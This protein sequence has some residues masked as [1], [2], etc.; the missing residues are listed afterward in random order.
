MHFDGKN[1]INHFPAVLQKAPKELNFVD[2]FY[3]GSGLGKCWM[4]RPPPPR[5]WSPTSCAHLSPR[6]GGGLEKCDAKTPQINTD[7]HKTKTE[8][9]YK[10]FQEL[11]PRCIPSAGGTYKFHPSEE[12]FHSATLHVMQHGAWWIFWPNHLH[13]SI[14]QK[15]KSNTNQQRT[16]VLQKMQISRK[17]RDFKNLTTF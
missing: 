7:E 17:C 10:L 3:G 1:K 14:P 13:F 5:E 2:V 4:A 8:I 12:N 6:R 11:P 16:K 9:A 15:H